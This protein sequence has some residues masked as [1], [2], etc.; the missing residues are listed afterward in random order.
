VHEVDE[1]LYFSCFTFEYI[2]FWGTL[3]VVVVVVGKLPIVH[4]PNSHDRIDFL[5]LM[6]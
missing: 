5:L 6:D 1:E 2:F 4:T 3:V